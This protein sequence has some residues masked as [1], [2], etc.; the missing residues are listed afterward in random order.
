MDTPKDTRFR[1]EVEHRCIECGS[2]D[3]KTRHRCRLHAEAYNAKRS[4]Y[5]HQV[6]KPALAQF[7]T[8]QRSAPASLPPTESAA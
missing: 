1:R 8:R 4:Q 7:R 6:V 3:L 2:A 5:Y